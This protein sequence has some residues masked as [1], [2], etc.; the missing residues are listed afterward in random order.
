MTMPEQYNLPVLTNRTYT[1]PLPFTS[2]NKHTSPDPFILTYRG[3]Y[4]CYATHQDGVQVSVSDD[5]T[6]WEHLGWA[7]QLPGRKN[8]WAPSVIHANGVFYM[9]NSSV[10][11]NSADPHDGYMQVSTST[12]PTGPFEYQATLFNKFSI[13]SQIVRDKDGQYYFFYST[14]DTTGLNPDN[15]GTSILVDRMVDFYTLAGKPQAIVI[16]TLDEEV[17]EHNR[18]GDGRNWHTIEGATYITH[19]DTGYLTY[20][21]NAY[22]RE[23]Y[24][25]SYSTAQ[26]AGKTIGELAWTKYPSD[27]EFHALVKRNDFVE[28]TG[29]NSITY[30]PN[31]VDPW[32]VYHGRDAQDELTADVEQRTMRMDPL[33]FDGGQLT[34]NAP[35]YAAQ[36]TP[37]QADLS[38]DFVNGLGGGWIANAQFTAGNREVQSHPQYE[39]TTLVSSAKFTNFVASIDLKAQLTHAGGRFGFY[40]RYVDDAN[41]TEVLFDSGQNALLVNEVVN[42]FKTEV[43]RASLAGFDLGIFQNLK[44]T[45]QFGTLELTLEGKALLSAAVLPDH[46]AVALGARFTHATF[47]AVRVTEHVF[48]YGQALVH[49]P[50]FFQALQP[51][52][53]TEHGVG[54][55][56]LR[57]LELTGQPLTAHTSYGLDFALTSKNSVVDYYPSY[58]DSN[59]YIRVLAGGG[60]LEVTQNCNG[61]LQTLQAAS[62]LPREFS[63]HLLATGPLDTNAGSQLLIRALGRST[64]TQT[65]PSGT[66]RLSIAGAFLTGF[67]ATSRAQDFSTIKKES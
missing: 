48:L 36:D 64:L 28:G 40:P 53:I 13:D 67:S 31:Q 56:Y 10:P 46:S 16:P 62:D 49:L 66:Q 50:Q 21:G 33:F 54:Q 25:V 6:T 63:L 61:D 65:A 23:N 57:R 39:L 37:S 55:G 8:Y 4:F 30:A 14:N 2:G 24:F 11:A 38:D 41:F 18:F 17:F 47:G 43:A 45:K 60:Q 35:S 29:H 59:N 12:S 22:V 26:T 9:Y 1:N 42:N 34:T 52:A 58:T 3:Q 15:P 32:I 27:Y 51:I 20:S 5:L 19:K 44:V 7:L